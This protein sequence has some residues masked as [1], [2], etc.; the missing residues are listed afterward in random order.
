MSV[1]GEEFFEGQDNKD[2][3]L[4]TL[5][6]GNG[7]EAQITNYGGI[8]VSLL[9]PDKNGKL[10]DV[11]LGYDNI[12]SYFDNA[13]YFGAIIGRHANRIEDSCF[14]ING[15]SYDLE[16]NELKNHL[17]GG[18]EG[19]HKVIWNADNDYKDR[20]KSIK[21][22]YFSKDGEQNYPGN[23]NVTVT[24]SVTDDNSFRID[25]CA[26]ADKDTVVN[27]TNHSYFN[28]SG[29]ESNEILG[30]QLKIF[31]DR[32]TPI[33]EYG[34][35]NG[36]MTEVKGTPLD[37][38]EMKTIGDRIFSDDNQIVNGKGFDHNW[39][40]DA[41]G[42]ISQK[43]AEVFDPLS[44]RRMEVYTT[45]PGLQFYSGNN[46]KDS[47]IGKYGVPYKKRSGLCLETQFFP[48]AL[49]HK[50]FPSPILKA[51]NEYRHTTIYKFL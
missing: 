11:V 24:Y 32:F 39:I 19:F 50:H 48:N 47:E 25:Y 15:I 23:L 43:A 29:K 30:H 35:P 45:K 27:L 33:D 14:E 12:R 5:A 28:L 40:L 3:L 22:S 13:P 16:R 18:S 49:K 1:L 44:G 8:V 6:N 31:G 36:E 21:L 51:G 38:T 20:I 37:F 46:I 17:H 34:I 4:Y 26:F 42:D 9:V 41:K 7:M 10:D 2:I